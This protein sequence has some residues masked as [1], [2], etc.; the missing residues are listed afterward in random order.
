MPMDVM[1]RMIEIE[2][3]SHGKAPIALELEHHPGG[4]S[5]GLDVGD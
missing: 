2:N 4:D 3:R 1:S 5:P